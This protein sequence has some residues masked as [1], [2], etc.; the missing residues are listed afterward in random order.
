[1]IDAVEGDS[2]IFG[3]GSVIED[4]TPGQSEEEEQLGSEPEMADLGVGD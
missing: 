3:R 1:V 2:V 4:E